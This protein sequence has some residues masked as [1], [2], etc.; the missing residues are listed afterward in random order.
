MSVEILRE[1]VERI[2][3]HVDTHDLKNVSVVLHGGEPLLAG[4][5]FISIVFSLFSEKLGSKVEF[6]MQSNLT[7]LT[8]EIVDLFYNFHATIGVSLDGPRNSNDKHRV[9]H[10]G[11]SSFDQVMKGLDLL[12]ST[13]KGRQIF[14]GILAVIDPEYDPI[15]VYEF[16]RSLHP[17]GID[18][19]L[20][21]A[22]HERWPVHKLSWEDTNYADWLIRL[23]DYWWQ[24]DNPIPIRFFENIITL[25]LG[26]VS[27]NEALGLGTVNLLVIET[28][29]AIEA[30]DTLKIDYEGAPCLGLDVF[31]N[32]ID[33]AMIHPKITMRQNAEA[34]LST[35]CTECEIVKICGGGYLPH[36]Y[37][38]TASYRNPSVYCSDLKKL[39]THVID[40][41]D[42]TLRKSISVH[43]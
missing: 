25:R 41:T 32:S 19:L 3:E 2:T 21:D 17:R 35:T 43:P 42:G 22:T 1:T 40:V 18:F 9:T 8:P 5:D 39:I 28:D 31:K 30:V 7:L 10:S 27:D 29:G 12:R 36:R 33:E 4:Y 6:G 34:E 13:T 20:P 24:Q 16:F 14:S 37:S 26:G 23:F 15:E 11:A 38:E